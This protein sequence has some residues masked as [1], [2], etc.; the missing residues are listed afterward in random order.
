MHVLTFC[1]LSVSEIIFHPFDVYTHKIDG[2]PTCMWINTQKRTAP[3]TV[4]ELCFSQFSKHCVAAVAV[5]VV[6]SHPT[7]LELHSC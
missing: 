6:R 1:L 5:V 3:K 7:T 4:N 2:K